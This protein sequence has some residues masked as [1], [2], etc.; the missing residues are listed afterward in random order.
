MP[1]E[2]R[3]AAGGSLGPLPGRRP[4]ILVIDDEDAIRR[5]L[6]RYLERRGWAVE[7]APDG[8]AALAKLLRPDADMR[9]DVILCDLKMPGVSGPDLY[10]RLVVEA[11]ALARRL[12]LSTG[13]VTAT[14]VADFL[15]TVSVPVLEKPFELNA[16]EALAEMIRRQP[17]EVP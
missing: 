3:S 4:S 7:D 16:L 14:D 8:A 17:A 9:Y 13:D 2:R 6:R 10:R 12:I 5:V 15:A 1:R 11:P